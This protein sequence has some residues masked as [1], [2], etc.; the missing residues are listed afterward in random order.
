M[1]FDLLQRSLKTVAE[2]RAVGLV[3]YETSISIHETSELLYLSTDY[4]K[5][6]LESGDLPFEENKGVRLVPLRDVLIYKKTSYEKRRAALAE[7]TRLSQEMG[8]Y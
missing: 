1:V 2:G 5:K 7:L 4:V 3:S 8:T 6:L